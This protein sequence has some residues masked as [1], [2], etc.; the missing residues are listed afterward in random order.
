MTTESPPAGRTLD[1]D[2]YRRLFGRRTLLL[3]EPLED[4]NAN[5]LCN[6]LVLLAAEDPAA[7][8]RLLINSPGGSVPGMLAIRECLR[9]IPYDVVTVD[10]EMADGAKQFCSTS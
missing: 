2:L 10:V 3:G 7:D 4:W 9:A 6:G 5:R 8:I 1:E